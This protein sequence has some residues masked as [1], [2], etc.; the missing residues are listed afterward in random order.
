[1]APAG[2]ASSPGTDLIL[3]AHNPVTTLTLI[4]SADEIPEIAGLLPIYRARLDGLVSHR[5]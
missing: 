5:P 1:V 2:T 3:P 4:F